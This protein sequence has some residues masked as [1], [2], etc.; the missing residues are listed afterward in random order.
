LAGHWSLSSPT[1][2][3]TNQ[4][5]QPAVPARSPCATQHRPSLPPPT[6]PPRHLQTSR[7]RRRRRRRRP[8]ARQAKAAAATPPLPSRP[9]RVMFSAAAAA[10]AAAEAA[11]AAAGSAPPSGGRGHWRRRRRGWRAEARDA[12]VI[13]ARDRTVLTPLSRRAV[14]A[15]DWTQASRSVQS[16]TAP[17]LR[18]DP[19]RFDAPQQGCR[20]QATFRLRSAW[21]GPVAGLCNSWP[22]RPP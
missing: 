11:A 17:I 22:R 7:R 2:K 21:A 19:S 10:A 13:A 18:V 4:R 15:S 3:L 8:T 5:Q 16:G 6:P 1:C 20:T 9:A 14:S 12:A